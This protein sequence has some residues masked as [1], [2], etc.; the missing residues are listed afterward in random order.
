LEAVGQTARKP[1]QQ[2]P[3]LSSLITIINYDWYQSNDT[4]N[5]TTEKHQTIQEQECK[6]E[7]N[8]Y[9]ENSLA[10]L[11]YLN[12]RTGKKYRDPSFIEARLKD[13]G[14]VDDC[15]RIIDTKMQD[16]Y[17]QENP[18]YLNPQTLFRKIHWDQYLNEA[19][20]L[21]AESGKAWFKPPGMEAAHE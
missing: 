13:G 4:T 21:A 6:N 19:L 15:R 2:N 17:F 7:K 10:I 11:A 18:K 16:P 20:P 1:I 14:T 12:Q 3:R 5:D 9:R 8:I